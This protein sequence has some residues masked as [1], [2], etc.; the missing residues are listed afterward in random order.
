MLAI[1]GP[2]DL[3]SRAMRAIGTPSLKRASISDVCFR[4]SA[5]RTLCA[6]GGGPGFNRAYW[7]CFIK[8]LRTVIGSHLKPAAIDLS[9]SPFLRLSSI[10][11][12]RRSKLR[13]TYGPGPPVLTRPLRTL[14]SMLS[15][16]VPINKWSGLTHPG[17]SQW[18]KHWRPSGISPLAMDQEKRCARTMLAGRLGRN[19]PYPFDVFPPVHSQQPSS[20]SLFTFSKNLSCD[21]LFIERYLKLFILLIIPT[22]KRIV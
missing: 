2:F 15:W 14:S 22:L 16:C 20:G 8:N 17:V 13:V 11:G 3:M 10:S 1:V 4:S 12:K 18:C 7:P 21:V 19:W 5:V 9:V 6:R